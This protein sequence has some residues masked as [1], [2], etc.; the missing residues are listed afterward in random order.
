MTAN[1]EPA[2][3]LLGLWRPT[4]LWLELDETF[5]FVDVSPCEVERLPCACKRLQWASVLSEAFIHD[6]QTSFKLACFGTVEIRVATFSYTQ[7]A[8]G[9]HAIALHAKRLI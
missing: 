6:P 2:M 3:A 9:P 8:M 7:P 1:V 4:V 5:Q